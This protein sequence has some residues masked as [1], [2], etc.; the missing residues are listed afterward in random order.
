MGKLAQAVLTRPGDATRRLAG[1]VRYT[2]VTLGEAQLYRN[3]FI[4]GEPPSEVILPQNTGEPRKSSFF[5][6]SRPAGQD[7]ARSRLRRG[8]STSQ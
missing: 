1:P 5:G 3:P 2:P 4:P 6:A 7:A 8:T